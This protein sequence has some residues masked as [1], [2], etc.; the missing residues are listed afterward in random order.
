VTGL[1]RSDSDQLSGGSK[2]PTT[3]LTTMDDFASDTDSDYTSYWRDWVSALH[4]F[5]RYTACLLEFGPL[6]GVWSARPPALLLA[7]VERTHGEDKS[8]E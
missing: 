2:T 4:F 1:S 7:A 6:V 8:S 5:F 3:T